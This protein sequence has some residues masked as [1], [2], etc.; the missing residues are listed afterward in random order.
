MGIT[1]TSPSKSEVPPKS[2]VS[3]FWGALQYDLQAGA[4]IQQLFFHNLPK[5]AYPAVTQTAATVK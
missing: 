5:L 2:F 4:V 1:K 3:N